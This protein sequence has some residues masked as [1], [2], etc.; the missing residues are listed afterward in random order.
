M[1]VVSPVIILTPWLV[2][3]YRYGGTAVYRPNWTF[4]MKM[5]WLIWGIPFLIV[6][7]LGYAL[8]IKTHE[9]DPYKP[10]PKEPLRVQ[11][12]GYGW[13][14]LFIYPEQGI[15]TAGK[16]VFPVDRSLALELTSNTAMQAFFIPALGSQIYAMNNMVTRL[17]LAAYGPGAFRGQSIQYNG[18]QFHEQRFTAEALEPQAFTDFV[19]ATRET[20][21]PMGSEHYAIFKRRSTLREAE[22]ELGDEASDGLIRFSHVPEGLFEAIVDGPLIV[23]ALLASEIAA[24]APKNIR[25][26]LEA[27]AGASIVPFKKEAVQ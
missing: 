22:R 10:L 15:A 21:I 19:E 23:Q 2:W 9:L 17:H 25:V 24:L 8:W 16:L 6:A 26:T 27:S 7:I 3:R 18:K 11:V 13:K 14:W 1:I 5:E 12:V 4:S 20:G